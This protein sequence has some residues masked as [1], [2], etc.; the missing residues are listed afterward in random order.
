MQALGTVEAAAVPVAVLIAHLLG[1]GT[2]A[3]VA[4]HTGIGTELVKAVQAAAVA[5]LLHV[6]LPLQGVTAVVAVKLGHG[7]HLVPA[8][9][10]HWP[11]GE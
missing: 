2:D 3:L 8:G 11:C 1:V 6:V 4:F 5:I 9:I 10:S 7:A